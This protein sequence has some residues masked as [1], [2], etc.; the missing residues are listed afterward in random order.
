MIG[1]PA[2]PRARATVPWILVVLALGLHLW[3]LYTPDPPDPGALSFPGIDKLAHVVL[4]A[5]PTWALVKALPKAWMGIV[6]M[7][8]HVPVSE[9]VQATFLAGSRGGEWLDALADLVGIAV[10]WWTAV[11]ADPL[12]QLPAAKADAP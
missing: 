1:E 8:I 5:V 9:V 12:R 10:G 6:A 7:V 11:R 3:G 2:D 4:F